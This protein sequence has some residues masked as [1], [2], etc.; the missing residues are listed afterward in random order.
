MCAIEPAQ[1]ELADVS[2]QH[3]LQ[4]SISWYVQTY[5]KVVALGCFVGNM[6]VSV[7]SR[8]KSTIVGV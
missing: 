3:A 6:V 8:D 7:L 5:F 2:R 4:C 1:E